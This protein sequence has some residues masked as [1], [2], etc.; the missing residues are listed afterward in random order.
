MG[1]V[2]AVSCPWFC[3]LTPACGPS[4]VPSGTLAA[5]S[6]PRHFVTGRS[7][8]C[9]ST[10]GGGGGGVSPIQV[11]GPLRAFRPKLLLPL[12][13]PLP[14]MALGAHPLCVCL[15]G[16]WHVLGW[17]WRSR[18]TSQPSRR[19][20]AGLGFPRDRRSWQD[21]GRDVWVPAAMEGVCAHT[22]MFACTAGTRLVHG[23]PENEVRAV[24]RSLRIS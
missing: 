15:G 16:R 20:G 23:C 11:S 22:R 10:A 14:V 2:S 7:G 4:T 5:P 18:G 3:A 19:L 13:R 9:T 1:P 17:G 6:S 12:Q 8:C 24:R 21:P